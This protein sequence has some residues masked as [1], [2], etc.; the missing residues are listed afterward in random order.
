MN[1]N[2]SRLKYH[3]LK[4]LGLFLCLCFLFI[5]NLFA[6]NEL[7]VIRNN[8]LP[9][10]DLSNSLNHYLSNKSVDLLKQRTDIISEI[11]T[12]DEWK[13]RQSFINETLTD[14]VGPFPEKTPLNAKVVGSLKKE[15][16]K[17]EHIVYE[18]QPG[19][20]VTS[21]I[22]IPEHLKKG[23][24]AP[25]II[26]CSGHTPD[27]Y[28][29]PVYLHVIANLVKKG[30][31]VFAFDP[32]G[33]G[34]RFEYL[35]PETGESLVSEHSYA[36]IQS[37]LIGSSQAR[38]MIWDGI[39]AVDYLLT[40]KEVDAARIGITGRSGGGTQ[41]AYIAAMDDR[42]YATAPENYLTNFT[43]LIQ[44][45][46]PQDAEQNLSNAIYRGIDQ[47]DFLLVRAPKPALMITTSNDMFSI[48][49]AK[50]TESE[51]S[52]IYKAYKKEENF[53]LVE[54]DGGHQSTEKN[55]VA[56]YAFFQKH[57]QNPGNSQ[58]EK[59]MAFSPEEVRVTKT[60]QVATS[61]GGE[62]LHSLNYRKAEEYMKNLEDSRRDSPNHI[63]QVI[64]AAKELSGYHGGAE[65]GKPVLTGRIQREGYV[66]EKYFVNGNEDHMVPYLLMTPENPNNK[67]VIYLDPSGK[68]NKSSEGG[69]IEWLVKK[70]FTV[71]APDLI[72][73]GETGPPTNDYGHNY[74]KLWFNAI[75]INKSLVG[76]RAEDVV[77]LA[78]LLRQHEGLEAVYGVAREEMSPVL[79]HAAAFDATISRIALVKPYSSYH[80]IMK[81]RFYSSKFAYS[82]VPGSLEFYDLPDLAAS[83]APRRLVMA[84]T[85]NGNSEPLGSESSQ[86]DFNFINTTYKMEKALDQLHILGEESYEKVFQ[87]LID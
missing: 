24:K 76:I 39:R 11:N 13:E 9:Y 28:R 38:D 22:F 44:T 15:N 84:A 33:Q 79:L 59:T 29:S 63:P 46:G 35:D 14:I 61:L 55:R 58:D 1:F 6:Q 47:P 20:Y 4:T 25:A 86:R 87:I 72:G 45:I 66:I 43:R 26:Y 69:E 7:D 56:M 17:I 23:D 65:F 74:N 53:S 42:I 82:L 8:W 18:S 62:T 19:F 36:G 51:V 71:L 83:L 57:L 81:N 70:G 3:N 64:S 50:E 10:N 73:A 2:I 77:G 30:F 54:D 41:S 27:G 31:I 75:L 5:G 12:L 85:T 78:H 32:V 49:G 40:R 34:E 67:A 80:S 48:Q 68:A 60:G 37:F 21:S 16:Y 52:G